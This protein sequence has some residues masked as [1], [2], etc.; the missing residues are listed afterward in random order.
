[1]LLDKFAQDAKGRSNKSEG[2]EGA[3]MGFEKPSCSSFTFYPGDKSRRG[4]L[5]MPAGLAEK[6]RDVQGVALRISL[7]ASL[8]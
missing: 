6:I 7:Y 3:R 2:E 4:H 1:M 5:D 8:S